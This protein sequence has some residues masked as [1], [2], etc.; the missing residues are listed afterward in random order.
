MLSE[1]PEKSGEGHPMLLV[2]ASREADKSPAALK[3]SG[4]STLIAEAGIYP[5]MCSSIPQERCLAAIN[6]AA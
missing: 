2:V 6:R 1:L 4:K 3:R 5:A